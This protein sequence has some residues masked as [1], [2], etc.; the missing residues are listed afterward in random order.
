[1]IEQLSSDSQ[2]KLIVFGAKQIRRLWVDD[3]WYFSIVDIVA[4]LTDSDA[5]SKYWTAM[6]RREEKASGFQL[7]TIC[8]QLKLTSADGKSYK[9]EAVNTE[10]AFR[11]IQSIPSPKAEPFKRWL[12]QVGYERVQEIENPELA[13][14]R[15]RQLFKAKGYPDDWIEKRVRGIAVRDELTDEWQKRGIAEQKDFAILTSEISK[16]TFGVTPADYKKLKGLKRENLRDHM[17]D[18]ELIFTMLG[19]AA[20]TEIARNKD[21]QGFTENHLAARDGGTVAGDA[22]RQL[23]IKSGKKVVTAN[24][25]LIDKPK[26]KLP[27]KSEKVEQHYLIESEHKLT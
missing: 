16:A 3:Q 2:D 7:S 9:T 4:A 27:S 23:E 24:N 11:I 13:Q 19:E 10:A 15:M 20:T 12:A 26:P 1:M 25:Y 8:R 17:T 18:L 14:Q 22:R 5:P 21:A 6:K